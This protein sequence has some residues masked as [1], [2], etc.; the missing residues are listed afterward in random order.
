MKNLIKNNKAFLVVYFLFVIAVI[1]LLSIYGKKEAQ[2]IANQYYSAFFDGFFFYSTK[3]V[4]W[5][6][7][8]VI[9]SILLFKG[10]KWAINGLLIYALT[11]LVTLSLKR[12]VFIDAMRPT[13][14]NTDFRLI[15]EDYGLRQLSNHSFPSG[16]T[17]A[18]F[19]LFCF[20][21]LISSNKKLGFTFGIIAVIVGYS[22]VYLSQHFFED[23][24]VGATIGTIGTFILYSL[25]SKINYGKWSEKPII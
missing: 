17:T 12:F 21:A 18:A 6:S 16:H 13:F 3:V 10:A 2:L 19:T 8:V 11:A 7:M 9:L 20:L 4:E 25:F 15:S 14:D 22:R 23:V 24:A 5:F 1:L